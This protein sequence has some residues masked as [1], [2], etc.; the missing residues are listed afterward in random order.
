MRCES[1]ILLGQVTDVLAVPIQAVFREGAVQ[2]V[3][4][5][6]NGKYTRTPV[7]VGRRSDTYAEVTVGLKNGDPVL[8]RTPRPSELLQE[9]WDV[10]ALASVGVEIGEDGQPRTTR[11]E[12]GTMPVGFGERPEGA[13]DRGSERGGGQPSGERGRGAEPA[14]GGERAEDAKDVA[15]GTD[16]ADAV[17]EAEGVEEGTQSGASAPAGAD[18]Q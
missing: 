14:A 2:Y 17:V 8:V 11:P 9:A 15:E 1:E 5:P 6:K 18:E 10:Q 13:R 3:H 7:K 4:S 12:G 16:S